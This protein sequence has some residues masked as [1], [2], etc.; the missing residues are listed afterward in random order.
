MKTLPNKLSDKIS[1]KIL[2]VNST[3]RLAKRLYAVNCLLMAPHK[4]MTIPV[5]NALQRGPSKKNICCFL[6]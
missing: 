5:E 1:E 6:G 4:P 2:S 3:T